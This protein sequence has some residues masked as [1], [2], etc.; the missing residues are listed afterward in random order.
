M[1]RPIW[2]WNLFARVW[3]MMPA[4]NLPGF[5]YD[6]AKNRYFKIQ[7]GHQRASLNQKTIPLPVESKVGTTAD[8]THLP[9]I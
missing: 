4:P 5:V 8:L 1:V 6:E 9:F 7:A 2:S 3:Q